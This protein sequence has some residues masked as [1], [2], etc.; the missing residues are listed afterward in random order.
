[1]PARTAAAVGADWA[2]VG[3]A[4]DGVGV[5]AVLG[6]TVMVTVCV[7]FGAVPLDAVIVTVEVPGVVGVPLMTP[8]VLSIVSPAGSPVAVYVG[9]GVP[10]AVTVYE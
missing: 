9:V 2:G 8:V 5:A 4:T 10:V 6:C 7:S 1:L 3:A